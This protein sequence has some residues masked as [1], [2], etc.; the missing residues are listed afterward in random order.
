MENDMEKQKIMYDSGNEL[1]AFAAKQINYHVMGYYP[2]TPSTQIAE[3]LDVMGAEGLHDIALIA[4]EGEHSAAGICYGASAAGGRVFNATSANGLLY[5]LEQFPVQSGTRMPMVMNVACRTVSGPLC[6]KGDHSDIMY[7][8]NTG[9]IILFADD[10]QMVYDF[11]LIALKLAEKVNLPVVVAFDGFFTSHQKQKCMVFSEDETVQHF[12]GK[13]LSC[14]NP[15]IS[16]FAGNDSTGENRFYSV[17]DLNH[18]VSVGSYMNEPDII[19]NKYQLFLAM[20]ETRK[21]FPYCLMNS[22]PSPEECT[23]FAADICVKMQILSFFCSVPL[24][25]QPQLQQ[26]RCAKRA[27]ALASSH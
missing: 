25:T 7:L 4:A 14:D 11:N 3:N 27:S 15:E 20:E 12:I 19:N 16:A 6:I 24:F 2:I 8:L 22:P 18:P 10:P 21:N 23:L 9:W 13:K 17:L 5:A 26:I 1:A